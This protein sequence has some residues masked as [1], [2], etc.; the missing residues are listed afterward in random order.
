MVSDRWNACFSDKVRQ[1][2]TER[3]IHGNAQCVLN[4]QNVDVEL[5]NELVQIAT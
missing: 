2:Q 5:L 3:N 4:A 1:S